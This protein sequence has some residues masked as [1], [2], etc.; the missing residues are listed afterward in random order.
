MFNSTHTLVG[1]AMTRAG[2]GRGTP[3]ATATAALAANF[4]DTDVVMRAYG[5]SVFLATHRGF[6][7]SIAGI[8]LLSFVL[9]ALIYIL[10]VGARRMFGPKVAPVRF[11][12]LLITALLAMLT[13]PLLDYTNSY[14]VRC[15][16]PFSTRWYAWDIV[17]VVSP[18]LDVALLFGLLLS[19]RRPARRFFWAAAALLFVVGFWLVCTLAHHQALR[20]LAAS[21]VEG[22]TPTAVGAFPLPLN[23]FRW[24]SVIETKDAL[25]K[26]NV[27]SWDKPTD[28]RP[29]ASARKPGP[30]A[31]IERSRQAYAVKVF[32]DFARFPIAKIVPSP[33]GYTVIWMDFRFYDPQTHVGFTALVEL[34]PTL[35]IL[36]DRFKYTNRVLLD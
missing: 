17:Y 16:L 7:H 34:S 30:E 32:L 22:Q 5:S 29:L 36:S 6:T 31:A 24:D 33:Q 3:W 4:P 8:V 20:V 2:L 27:F 14:G 21:T 12:P 11:R 26:V 25:Y 23:P 13:H 18:Y 35:E 19:L 28:L 1:L 10:N 9:T 15:F